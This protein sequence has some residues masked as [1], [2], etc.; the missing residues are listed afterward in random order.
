MPLAVRRMVSVILAPTFLVIALVA[1]SLVPMIA[2]V[3][4]FLQ[5]AALMASAHVAIVGGTA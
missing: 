2:C 1:P 3:N 4:W 5:S